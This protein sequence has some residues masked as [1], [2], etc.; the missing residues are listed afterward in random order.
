M[1]HF[2]LLPQG[3]R[4]EQ[5]VSAKNRRLNV[6]QRIRFFFLPP[7]RL[8]SLLSDPVP[9]STHAAPIVCLWPRSSFHLKY[10]SRSSRAVWE[11]NIPWSIQ[12][13]KD[14]DPAKVFQLIELSTRKKI[15]IDRRVCGGGPITCV[16]V[17]LFSW[18]HII[19]PDPR[20]RAREI[21]LWLESNEVA[22]RNVRIMHASTFLC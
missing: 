1:L 7:K 20:H 19:R 2:V 16:Y 13:G 3:R 18:R 21:S 14:A 10:V 22:C 11:G 15:R 8:C 5:N 6:G 17:N 9:H 12:Q 4:R